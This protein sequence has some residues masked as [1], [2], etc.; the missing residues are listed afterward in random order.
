MLL[1]FWIKSDWFCL[2]QGFQ[3]DGKFVA[4][5]ALFCHLRPELV[6]EFIFSM[7]YLISLLINQTGMPRETLCS[8][9]LPR[10]T[11]LWRRHKSMCLNWFCWRRQWF[12]SSNCCK[13]IWKAVLRLAL[14]WLASCS[15]PG[16]RLFQR[17]TLRKRENSKTFFWL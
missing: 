1:Y 12:S 14:M 15:Q 3:S 16:E 6:T 11:C 17:G 8:T 5:V 9:L 10:W 7:L 13:W 2:D 4:T